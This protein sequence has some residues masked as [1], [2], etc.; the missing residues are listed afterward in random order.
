MGFSNNAKKC[1][2][3]HK[4]DVT[5]VCHVTLFDRRFEMNSCAFGQWVA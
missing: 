5:K 3:A 2:M 4:C 1:D